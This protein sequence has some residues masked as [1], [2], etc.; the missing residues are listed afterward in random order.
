MKK[1]G[2]SK[3]EPGRTAIDL[4]ALIIILIPEGYNMI[5]W[6]VKKMN[7]KVKIRLIIIAFS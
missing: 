6:I 4:G 7:N 1:S 5:G 2:D 3:N